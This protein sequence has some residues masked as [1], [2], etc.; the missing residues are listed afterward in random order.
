LVEE[1]ASEEENRAALLASFKALVAAFQKSQM[2]SARKAFS[3]AKAK[4]NS[5]VAALLE[6]EGKRTLYESLVPSTA[7]LIVVPSVLVEHWKVGKCCCC[8]Y[9]AIPCPRSNAIILCIL[10]S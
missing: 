8:L 5:R 9:G 7:T 6:E 10:K 2:R 3:N 4:P 1:H